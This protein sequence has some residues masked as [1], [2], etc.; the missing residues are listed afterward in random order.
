VPTVAFGG[1]LRVS[2]P[3]AATVMLSGPVMVN[4]GLLESVALTVKA[5]V[6]AV[7]GVPLTAQL[8]DRLSP[9]GRVPPV[10]RQV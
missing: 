1:E 9:A 8:A 7:V 5:D 10:C 3:A 4:A 6:P 2:E